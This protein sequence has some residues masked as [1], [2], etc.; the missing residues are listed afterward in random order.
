MG[1][2][3]RA[4]MRVRATARLKVRSVRVRVWGVAGALGGGAHEGAAEAEQQ[5]EVA[6]AAAGGALH[7]E[8]TVTRLCEQEGE[9]T[10]G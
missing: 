1:R 10:G 3:S 2:M 6:G 7:E 5:R 9:R 8:P 4:E